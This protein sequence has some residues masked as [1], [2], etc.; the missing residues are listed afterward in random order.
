MRHNNHTL[1]AGRQSPE[2]LDGQSIQISERDDK[3]VIENGVLKLEVDRG[4]C[5]PLARVWHKGEL[6]SDGGLEFLI[7]ADDGKSF[8][9]RH[10]CNVKFEI[11]ESGPMRTLMRWEGTHKDEAGKGHFDFLVRMTM[12]AGQPFVAWTTP[13]SIGST[14]RRRR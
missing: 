2:A 3:S 6:V 10:D 4:S 9:A 7:T 5:V 8:A 13:L 11:E 12:Y 1:V 14:R